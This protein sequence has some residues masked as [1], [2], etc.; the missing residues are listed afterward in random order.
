MTLD[1]HPLGK[2][3]AH[4]GQLWYVCGVS[5]HF[6]YM[7][8]DFSYELADRSFE[9]GGYDRIRVITVKEHEIYSVEEWEAEQREAL[10][11]KRQELELELEKIKKELKE[12]A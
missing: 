10:E 7:E 12:T 2:R 4:K 5:T 3:V 8:R 6:G 1:Y 11:V 9:S